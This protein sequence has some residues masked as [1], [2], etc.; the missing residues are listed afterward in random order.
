MVDSETYNSIFTKKVKPMQAASKYHYLL[1]EGLSKNGVE[2]QCLSNLPITRINCDR[3]IVS[4]RKKKYRNMQIQ[5]IPVINIPI[6][7]HM[8]MFIISFLKAVFSSKDTVI[9]YD[10]LVITSAYGALLGSKITGKKKI[11][12]VTD[13]PQFMQVGSNSLF[14]K[15]NN[16]IMKSADGYVLLTKDMNDVVNK[17]GKPYIIL[18]GHVDENMAHVGHKNID[19]EHRAVI[20]AG[21]LM[22]KYGIRNLCESFLKIAKPF[23]ELHIYGDG[24]YVN[25]LVQLASQNKNIIYHGNCPNNEVVRK[26]LEAVLLVNP[27]PTEG[28]YT[29]YSFPSKTMEYMVSGTPVLTAKLQGIPSEY[30]EYVYYFDD[31]D[32]K[33]L[34]VALRKILDKSDNDLREYGENARR[35]VLQNK[36]NTIQAKKIIIFVNEFFT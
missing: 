19:S 15:I 28:E 23:E 21:S 5:Y 12:I 24:D 34:E 10:V 3:L 11:G 22:Q 6:I 29:K 32:P 7:R 30:D 25:E 2:V 33:G 18:E 35:F 20:Y 26:E 1:C 27:R 16:R 9:L 13:L 31:R 8:L 14:L 36:T 17:E 4:P